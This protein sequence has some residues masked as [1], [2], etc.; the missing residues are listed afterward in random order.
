MKQLK[1]FEDLKGCV[2]KEVVV[3]YGDCEGGNNII[4]TLDNGV[5]DKYK[6]FHDQDCC[7]DVHI[8][9]IIGDFRGLIGDEIL[10]AEV[11][12]NNKSHPEDVNT[13]DKYI[14]DSFTWTFY[15]LISVNE[16]ITIRWMG[17]SNGYYSETVDFGKIDNEVA[18]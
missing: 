6:L 16:T 10:V 12:T 5:R 7:E 14:D 15:K 3:N 4:F 11:S 13:K 8:E 2:L 1:K 9:S 17:T 18:Q